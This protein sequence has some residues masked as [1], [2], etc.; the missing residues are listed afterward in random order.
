M[1]VLEGHC[2]GQQG[3]WSGSTQVER[4][5]FLV[6]DPRR[7]S[8]TRCGDASFGTKQVNFLLGD[9]EGKRSSFPK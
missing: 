7:R 6:V 3:K 1:S 8:A 4:S 2:G 9:G 5:F